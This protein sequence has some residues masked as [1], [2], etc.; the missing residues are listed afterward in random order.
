M[1]NKE[2]LIWLRR[3]ELLDPDSFL[4]VSRFLVER[5]QNGRLISTSNKLDGAPTMTTKKQTII[6]SGYRITVTSWENDADNYNTKV[7]EGLDLT[8]ATF[9]AELCKL[10]QRDNSAKAN[11][12]NRISNLYEPNEA[13]IE[14]VQ[15]AIIPLL[16]KYDKVESEEHLGD[17]AIEYLYE[18]GL[19]GGEFFTRVCDEWK[20]E[21]I[22][23]VIVLNDVTDNFV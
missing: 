23:D 17:H 4:P 10:M 14:R 13:E 3:T 6:P 19:S 18:L 20:M 16:R 1:D 11:W 7:L 22:P 12:N 2:E 15:A 21:F 8:S 9:Y 5:Y